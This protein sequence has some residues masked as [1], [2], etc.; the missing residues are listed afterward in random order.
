M[1]AMQTKLDVVSNN[2]ANIENDGLQERSG[3]L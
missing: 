2:L 1:T 3:K